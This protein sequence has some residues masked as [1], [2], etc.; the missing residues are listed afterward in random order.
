MESFICRQPNGLYC[1]HSTVVDCITDYN[2]TEDG[3]IEMCAEE[4]RQEARHTLDNDIRPFR[5][6]REHFRPDNMSMDEFEAILKE[7]EIN[8][9]HRKKTI[10]YW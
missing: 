7:M 3:Y 5:W 9:I 10:K 2:M 1:R 4:A 6:V 8:V